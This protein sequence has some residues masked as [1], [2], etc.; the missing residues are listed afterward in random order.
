MNT[1]R[2]QTLIDQLP[3]FGLRL[4]SYVGLRSGYWNQLLAIFSY[5]GAVSQGW[6][7]TSRSRHPCPL[8]SQ[9]VWPNH[10]INS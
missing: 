10:Q 7:T 3:R 8:I 2:R 5:H 1:A 9:S 6:G 4:S